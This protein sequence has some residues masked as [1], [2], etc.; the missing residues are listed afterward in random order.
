VGR[1]DERRRRSLDY[2]HIPDRRWWLELSYAP[3]E[4]GA[5]MYWARYNNAS[6]AEKKKLDSYLL[7]KNRLPGIVSERF[8][9]R[10]EELNAK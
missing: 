2:K 1:L 4:A 10:L 6:K 3:P 5:N 8:L 7:G 9:K